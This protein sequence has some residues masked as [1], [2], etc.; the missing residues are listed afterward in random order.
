VT[1]GDSS[2][3]CCPVGNKNRVSN[4]GKNRVSDSG[5]RRVSDTGKNR[6]SGR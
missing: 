3:C 6:V 1:A 4:A 5:K 2:L